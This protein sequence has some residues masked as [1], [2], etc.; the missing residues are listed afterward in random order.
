[1]VED[2]ASLATQ[3][4]WYETP[5]SHLEVAMPEVPTSMGK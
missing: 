5:A 3:V 1:M 4:E 2:F